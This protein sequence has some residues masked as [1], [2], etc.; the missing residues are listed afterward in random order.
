MND[1]IRNLFSLKTQHSYKRKVTWLDRAVYRFFY[2]WWTPIFRDRP[3]YVELF[4]L[5]AQG[6]GDEI[7][8][9]IQLANQSND[10]HPAQETQRG[11]RVPKAG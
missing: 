3:D 1:E 5:H 10:Q 4:K 7:V 9:A 2:W 11:R 6:K 8:K